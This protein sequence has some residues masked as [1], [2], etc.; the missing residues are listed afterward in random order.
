MKISAFELM[1]VQRRI[2]SILFCGGTGISE[3]DVL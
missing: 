1:V 3:K 2:S